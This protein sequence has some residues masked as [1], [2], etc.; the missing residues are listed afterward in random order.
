MPAKI[1]FHDRHFDSI[2][3][4]RG[5]AA[6]LVVLEHIS[7]L[8]CGAFGVDVFFCISGFMM[9]FSTHK[10]TS[11]FFRKRLIR[12]LPLYYLGTIGTFG[13][14]LFFPSMFQQSTADVIQLVKSL[15]FIPFDIGGGVLQ[16]IFRIGWTV[17]CEIFFYL[18]FWISYHISRKWRG[19]LCSIFLAVIVAAAHLLPGNFAPLIFYGDPVMLDFILGIL[20]YYAARAIYQYA[21]K[22]T[23][24]K[25]HRGLLEK[26]TGVL[27]LA[28]SCGLLFLLSITEYKTNILDFYRPLHW[29]VPSALAIMGFFIA[30]LSLKT[31]SALARLGDMSFSIYLVHYYPIMLIDRKLLAT[32]TLGPKLILPVLASLLLVIA[33][34]YAVWYFM[35]KK[36]TMWLRR[37][38][39]R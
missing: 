32:L 28:A 31:P 34:S 6:L 36:L 24:D 14:L 1:D 16:P 35:E 19:L 10:D 18:L 20:C 2:Q 22:E 21:Q 12:I 5:I 9:M 29:G 30:G 3:A 38:L 8:S 27:F 7:L 17:N 33:L 13:L 4:L 15:L 11:C 39:L 25:N 23:E 37:R 26:T